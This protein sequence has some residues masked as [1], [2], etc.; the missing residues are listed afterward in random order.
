M[1]KRFNQNLI[2]TRRDA[3]STPWISSFF[4]SIF[5]TVKSI[6]EHSGSVQQWRK[7]LAEFMRNLENRL[8]LPIGILPW[9]TK[10]FFRRKIKIKIPPKI[11]SENF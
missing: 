6:S 10:H 11:L 8:F 4:P 2:L 1:S 5:E 9:G 3:F 7:N